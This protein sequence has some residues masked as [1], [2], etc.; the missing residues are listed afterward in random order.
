MFLIF[1]TIPPPT[2]T[3][4]LICAILVN[5]ESIRNLPLDY[6]AA[7]NDQHNLDSW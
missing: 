3:H 5:K 1:L 4:C 7:L 2:H 6:L